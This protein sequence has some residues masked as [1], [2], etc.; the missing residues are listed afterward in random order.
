[1]TSADFPFLPAKAKVKYQKIT[2]TKFITDHALTAT[3]DLFP[4]I[5]NVTVNTKDRDLD[6]QK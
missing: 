6:Q 5:Y 3:Y 4:H 2:M 1:M